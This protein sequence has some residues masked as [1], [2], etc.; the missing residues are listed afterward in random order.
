MIVLCFTLC[1]FFSWPLAPSSNVSAPCETDVFLLM[2]NSWPVQ[3]SKA[4]MD[5]P[6][7]PQIKP[8]NIARPTDNS[9]SLGGKDDLAKRLNML[10]YQSQEFK[11]ALSL[12]SGSE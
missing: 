10:P 5:W 9:F 2:H 4:N 11:R 1:F 12:L 8:F 3:V 6:K 7:Q